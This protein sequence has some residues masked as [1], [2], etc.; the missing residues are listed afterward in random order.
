MGW[1]SFKIVQDSLTIMITCEKYIRDHKKIQL[2]VLYTYVN[3]K[4]TH[5]HFKY[6]F[7]PDAFRGG[8]KK[9]LGGAHP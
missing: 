3:K 2:C 4:K 8:V 5:T 9:L 6:I 7:Y 1:N